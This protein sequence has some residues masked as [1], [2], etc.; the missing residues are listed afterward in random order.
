[1]QGLG[2]QTDRKLERN[3]ARV[4]PTPPPPR[5]GADLRSQLGARARGGRCRGLAVVQRCVPASLL[6]TACAAQQVPTTPP[7][8]VLRCPPAETLMSRAGMAGGAD[9]AFEPVF[10]APKPSSKPLSPAAQ[11]LLTAK[12]KRPAAEPQASWLPSWPLLLS[13]FL[14]GGPGTRG[15]RGVAAQQ[16]IMQAAARRAACWRNQSQG[17]VQVKCWSSRRRRW[18]AL[19]LALRGLGPSVL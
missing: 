2:V 6:L 3:R 12:P 9:D 15:Q 4:T 18:A 1:M 8:A 16:T 5:L 14:L 7:P 17:R 13:V 19:L 10:V 11:A